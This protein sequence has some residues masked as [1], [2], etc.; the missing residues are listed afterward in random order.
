MLK[1]FSFGIFWLTLI[2]FVYILRIDKFRFYPKFDDIQRSL[3][4]KYSEGSSDGVIHSFSIISFLVWLNLVWL[5]VLKNFNS[6]LRTSSVLSSTGGRVISQFDRSFRL[7]P[8]TPW[9]ILS[10]TASKKLL[11][12]SLRFHSSA[13]IL[14]LLPAEIFGIFCGQ[15]P[16]A[17]NIL[18]NFFCISYLDSCMSF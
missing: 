13:D 12:H 6:F 11:H 17:Q 8:I 1:C 5:F 10:F 14:S 7:I 16:F 3:W 18:L 2:F 4:M 15:E 9:M